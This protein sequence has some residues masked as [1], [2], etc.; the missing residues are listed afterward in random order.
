MTINPYL[1]SLCQSEDEVYLCSHLVEL[2]RMAVEKGFFRYSSFLNERQCFL[3]QKTGESVGG[4]WEIWGGFDDA[5]RK[6]FCACPDWFVGESGEIEFPIVPL[7]ITYRQA[8]VLSHRDF[9]GALM[10][11]QIKREMI[12]DIV[13]GNGSCMV[14][15]HE[16][17]AP[18]IQSEL[19]QI[20]RVGVSVQEGI[21][22]DLLSSPKYEPIEIVV[23]SL[24]LD[25]VVA[26]LV[27]ISREQAMAMVQSGRVQVNYLENVS[28]SRPVTTGDIL[29]LRG[30]GKYRVGPVIGETKRGRVRIQ[31]EKYI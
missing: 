29:S 19:T 7:H 12:G 10:S 18:L 28:R 8:D 6:I 2:C 3:A 17:V 24:R 25:G 21:D 9:L 27:H 15:V 1:A 11:M 22:G 5:Q 31:V 13:P 26:A 30:Y 4:R 20:G 14:F 16:N 23:S